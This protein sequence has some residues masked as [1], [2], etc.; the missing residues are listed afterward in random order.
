MDAARVKAEARRLGFTVCGIARAARVDDLA[1]RRYSQWLDDGRN[2]CMDWAERYRDVRDDP[3]LLLEGARS[4]VMVAMNYYPAERQHSEAAQVAYYA[5]GR[6]Y[7]KVVRARLKRLAA[8]IADTTGDA[9]RMCVDSAPFRERYWAVKAGL[10][11]IGLNN[12]L[13]IKGHGSYF[14][15]GA[16]VTTL[17]LEP[18]EPCSDS[19]GE[20]GRCLRACPAGALSGNGAVDARRCLSCLTI[21]NHDEHL[22]DEAARVIGRRLFG[23]DDCQRCCPHNADAVPTDIAD[24]TPRPELLT[25]TPDDVLALDNDSY[26]HLFNGTPVRRAPLAVMQR[27]ARAIIDAAL[28]NQ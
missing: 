2:G 14:S 8:L 6:D 1:R 16:L 9:C 11:F 18:D 28:N 15:L 10:G 3:R 23:C 19:C 27:N 7:H 25:I 26:E 24:F 4:V 5:Y 21:E 20:C 22:P 13:I 17:D 12:Q